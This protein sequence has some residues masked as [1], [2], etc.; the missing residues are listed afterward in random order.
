M[1]TST[2]QNPTAG[3]YKRKASFDPDPNKA[4]CF[5]HHYIPQ[6]FYNKIVEP[7]NEEEAKEKIIVHTDSFSD[8]ELQ[9]ELVDHELAMLRD[10][11]DNLVPDYQV[12]EYEALQEKKHKLILGKRF[13]FNARNA[14][15]YWLRRCEIAHLEML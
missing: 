14:Y 5:K 7:K 3:E 13:H 2:F 9:L 11:L 12:Q 6:S 1:L 10:P 4:W 15:A 8:Y